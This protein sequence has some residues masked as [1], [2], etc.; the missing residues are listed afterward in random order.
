MDNYFQ[1]KVCVVTGAA[2][3]IGLQL[4]KDLLAARAVVFMADV[5]ADNLA[6]ARDG[7]G[8]DNAYAVVTDVT[9]EEQVHA[10]IERAAGHNGRLDILFNNAGIGGTMPW[11]DVTLDFW[12]RVLDINLWGVIHGLH[13]AV[14]LMRKQGGGHIVNT[15]SMA[16]L[17]NIPYQTVYCASKT[18][19]AAIGECLRFELADENIHV[20]TV[21][22]ANVTTPIF[23][24]AGA[25]P[26]DA[27]PVE[28]AVNIILDAVSRQESAVIFPEGS[29]LWAKSVQAVPEFREKVMLELARERR[30]NYQ[31]KG[32]YF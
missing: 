18:A 17:V 7:L 13:Y 1:D 11:E 9:K 30:R 21:Y 28:E 16:G 15:S 5:N 3:G 27:I 12:R 19:V 25:V 2:S 10:L 22:P 23:A 6:R 20:T 24:E 4:A 8:R 32:R 26:D 29:R 31:T 14:P